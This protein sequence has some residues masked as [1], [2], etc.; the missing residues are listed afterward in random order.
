MKNREIENGKW[1]P[2]SFY[3]FFSTLFCNGIPVGTHLAAYCD[4][5]S[6]PLERNGPPNTRQPD[7]NQPDPTRKNGRF[8]NRDEE[9]STYTPDTQQIA[10]NSKIRRYFRP[11]DLYFKTIEY[12]GCFCNNYSES[13][14]HACRKSGCRSIHGMTGNF[15]LLLTC[16][17]FLLSDISTKRALALVRFSFIVC[18]MRAAASGSLATI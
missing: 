12:S 10:P 14:K 13:Y 3:L 15:Q 18:L 11:R 2:D 17:P 6:G 9:L 16:S 4:A 5:F 7:T 8:C 1:F